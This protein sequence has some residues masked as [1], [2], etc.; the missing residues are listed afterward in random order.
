MWKT[1]K[2]SSIQL[3]P[4]GNERVVA[5]LNA[6][7]TGNGTLFTD[8]LSHTNENIHTAFGTHMTISKRRGK[9]GGGMD[10][11]W[12]VYGIC[13][14]SLPKTS[15]LD[16]KPISPYPPHTNHKNGIGIAI[17]TNPLLSCEYVFI[18][19]WIRILKMSRTRLKLKRKRHFCVPTLAHRPRIFM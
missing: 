19:E 9:R 15:L 8:V 5:K 18:V 2:L 6:W 1:K 3:R 11:I 16:A 12:S 4:N 10:V 14:K 17:H 7:C 13:R